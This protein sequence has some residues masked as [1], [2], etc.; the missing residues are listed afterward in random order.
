MGMRADMQQHV[1]KYST[2]VNVQ[3]L[4]TGDLLRATDSKSIGHHVDDSWLFQ[5]EN[6]PG[7]VLNNLDYPSD[8]LSEKVRLIILFQTLL[9][10]LGKLRITF[11]AQVTTSKTPGDN[12]RGTGSSHWVEHKFT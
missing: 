5:E 12:E 9:D 3:S 4:I 1:E 7:R 2:D 10:Q 6:S 8:D 11:A